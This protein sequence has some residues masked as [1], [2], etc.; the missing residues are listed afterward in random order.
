LRC[1]VADRAARHGRAQAKMVVKSIRMFLRYL[2]VHGV[3]APQL[4]DAI[5]PF[6]E[7]RLSAL[8]RYLPPAEVE[9]LLATAGRNTPTAKRDRAILLLLAR[10]GLRAGDVA[11]LR[12][13]DLDWRSG[14]LVVSGKGRRPCRLPLPQEV[15]DAILAYLADGRRNCAA[16]HVFLRSCAPVGHPL[17]SSTISTIVKVVAMRAGVAL[18][19]HAAAHALRHSVAT[20]LLRSGVRLSAIGSLLRHQSQETTAHYAKVDIEMLR[21]VAQPW[22]VEVAPC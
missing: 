16:E 17:H 2:A 4:V 15:G 6:A 19:P 14:T 13:G 8:P 22:P 12:L 18:P 5:A 11:S 20:A 1:F 9:K 7:W 3:C 21:K 10:L